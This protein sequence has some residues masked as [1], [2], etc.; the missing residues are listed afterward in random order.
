MATNFAIAAAHG[1]SPRTIATWSLAVPRTP[2]VMVPVHLDALAVRSSGGVWADCLMKEPPDDQPAAR[3]SLLPDPFK[4]LSQ[5]RPPGIY[6]HWALPDALT[7]GTAAQDASKPT[8]YAVPDRWLIVRISPSLTFGPARRAVRGWVLRSGEKTPVVT[9]LDQWTEPGTNTAGLKGPMTAL[10]HGDPAWAA[11]YDNVVNRLAFY[12]DLS[13]VPNGPLAYLVCGWYSDPTLDPL[14]ADI[15]SLTD[16]DAEMAK[17]SWELAPGELQESVSHLSRYI[18]AAHMVGLPTLEAFVPTAANAAQRVLPL[19]NLDPPQVVSAGSTPAPLDQSGHPVDGQYTTNGAWWPS[20]TIYHGSV[21]GIGWPGIGFPGAENGLLSGEVGGPPPVSQVNVALGNTLGEALAALVAKRDNAPGEARALEAFML[22]ALDDLEHADGTARVDARLHASEFGSLPGGTTTET[23]TQPE[24]GATQPLPKTPIQPA[25]GIFKN[26]GGTSEVSVAGLHAFETVEAATSKFAFKER[27]SESTIATGTLRDAL[28]GIAGPAT[29]PPT[30]RQPITVQRTLPRFFFPAD[31]V[32]LLEGADRSYKHGADGRFSEDGKLVCRLTGFAVTELACSSITGDP[33]RTAI[34]GDDVLERGAENGSIP[35]ECEDL[36]R[37]VVA[38]DPGSAAAAAQASTSLQGTPLISQTQNFMVEQTVWWATRD[39]RVDQAPL[40]TLSGISGMLPSPIAINPPQRPWTPLHL[41]WSIQFI[42]SSG[43]FEAWDLGELDFDPGNQ[44]LPAPDDTTSGVI[45]NGRALLTGGAA[46]TIAAGVRKAMQQAASAG[47]AVGLTP[48]LIGRLHSAMSGVLLEKISGL[49]IAGNGAGG[50]IDRSALDHVADALEHMDVLAGALD[51]FTTRLRGGLPGDGISKPPAGNPP[52][53]PFFPVRAGFV[54][55][56]RL[57]LVDCF[58][59]VLDLAGSSDTTLVDGK[60]ILKSEPLQVNGRDD[61]A[62]MAPRFT[63]PSR[64]WFR[65]MDAA[66]SDRE[67][68]PDISPVC[69]Y[70]L[71][72]HL[73]GALEFFDDAGTNL[74]MV[75]PDPSAGVVWEDAPGQASTVGTSPARAIP[76]AFLAGIAQGLLDWGIADT[77]PGAPGRELAVSAL[78]RIVDS[79]LWSVDP[80]GHTGDEH[81][82]LLMGHPVAVLRAKVRL[83]VQEPVTPDAVKQMRVPLRL[84][85]LVHWQDGLLGYFVNDDYRTLYCADAAV[86][87]FA[88][89]VGPGEGFLQQAN[90]VP[91]YYEEFD[92][93]LGVEATE[94]NTPV[95]HPYV[96]DSGILWIQPGQNVALTLLVEPHCVV[97]AT[98]GSLPR[99]EIGTRR[100]WIAAALAKISPTF[101]FGPVLVDPKR[102]RMPVA[103]EIEGTWSWDH[104]ADLST[105]AEDKVIN[106]NGDAMIP[107]DPAKGQEGWLRLTPRPQQAANS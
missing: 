50:P 56:L 42:P 53:S 11:Y 58:G 46:A 52:P 9:D 89:R 74:G 100:E 72:D 78:L 25:P 29:E 22:G 13:G 86:A 61:L 98:S 12:D 44:T 10:G 37:E 77:T 76:N 93:D 49:Q 31:P 15:H 5:P 101:R 62:E 73:D 92:K 59:Q 85:A 68:T 57:R 48:G 103:R 51:N 94:G 19:G 47:G 106:S 14:G 20:L 6:L 38:L 75:R 88:R 65:F 87:G 28:D 24:S 26:R 4:E 107:A 83:E 23:I 2:R 90:L 30:P 8:F 27:L 1:I 102:I 32:V 60:Q 67:A 18:Q 71:P 45:L 97:H 21:V 79:T 69:G 54:R 43:G 104:R 16:F 91:G 63:S 105:W 82:S 3:L 17:L 84:G 7:G 81:L 95:D 40:A 39:P 80:F 34:R 99:K 36:L 55:I 66:G 70:V 33:I 64:L 41:D 35:P 96:D